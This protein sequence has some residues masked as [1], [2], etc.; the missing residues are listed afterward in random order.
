MILGNCRKLTKK[1]PS[2]I[3]HYQTVVMHVTTAILS[4]SVYIL[5]NLNLFIV[6]VIS[7]IFNVLSFLF[8][9]ENCS[10]IL[11]SIFIVL[12]NDVEKH[13]CI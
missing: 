7:Y 5:Y 2:V 10:L 11:K 8:V 6:Y 3:L 9:P 4:H 13:S 1:V 12:S